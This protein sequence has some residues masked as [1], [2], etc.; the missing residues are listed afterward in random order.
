MPSRS[1][2]KMKLSRYRHSGAIHNSGIGATFCV[3][4]LVIASSMVDA[5]AARP[6]HSSR[7]AKLGAGTLSYAGPVSWKLRARHPTT[8]HIAANTAY[9]IDQ[10]TACVPNFNVGSTSTGYVSSASIDPRFDSAN[11][12]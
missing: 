5:Q 6:I 7:V 8:P 12:R 10:A 2:H 9:P 4:W 3:K 11:S 1:K